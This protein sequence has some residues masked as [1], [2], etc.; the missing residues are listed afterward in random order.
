MT[1]LAAIS[2][3]ALSFLSLSCKKATPPIEAEAKPTA[4]PAPSIAPTAAPDPSSIARAVEETSPPPRLSDKALELSLLEGDPTEYAWDHDRRRIFVVGDQMVVTPAF[5]VLKDGAFVAPEQGFMFPDFPGDAP[6]NSPQWALWLTYRRVMGR[7]PD[8]LWVDAS[9]TFG[10][11]VPRQ[12]YTADHEYIYQRQYGTWGRVKDRPVAAAPWSKGR[13]LAYLE[14]GEFKLAQPRKGKLGELPKQAP[15]EGCP[16]RVSGLA[17]A[18][19]AAGEV[20]LLGSDCDRESRLAIER[21]AADGGDGAA[22]AKSQIIPLP[23]P[24]QDKPLQTWIF[25]RSGVVYAVANYTGRAWLAEVRGDAVKEIKLP[26]KGIDAAHVASDG[27]LFLQ[28]TD[29]D[30]YRYDGLVGEGP[31]FTQLVMPAKYKPTLP[32]GMFAVS[33]DLVYVAVVTEPKHASLLLW[34]RPTPPEVLEAVTKAERRAQ[35]APSAAVTT[36]LSPEELLATFPAMD[37]ECKTPFVVFFLVTKSTPPDF[38]FPQTQR[39][40]KEFPGRE[41]LRVIDFEHRGARFVGAAAP[42]IK[43][44]EAL[45]EHWNKR[46]EK[47]KSRAACFAPP[48]G[49]RDV[50]IP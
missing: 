35:A 36:T 16:K 14:T 11:V 23:T 48:P 44:A 7:Y 39:L 19:T 3:M 28:G 24:E 4:S 27:S 37:A 13:T 9:G 45:V 15:G 1:G 22:L 41:A 30:I 33:R 18:I 6:E 26:I 47:S 25:A 10:M 38:N 17:M 29:G 43:A 21:W 40:V 12:N 20:A 34:S 49:A 46:D 31:G 5:A 2:M 42:D 50:K 8:D 32:M